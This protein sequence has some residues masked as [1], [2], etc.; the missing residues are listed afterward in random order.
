MRLG[1]CLLLAIAATCLFVNSSNAQGL[2]S[3]KQSVVAFDI[4]IAKI[5]SGSLAQKMHFDDMI[6]EAQRNQRMNEVDLTKVDRIIG[7]VSA[8]EGIAAVAGMGRGDNLPMDFFVRILFSDAAGAEKMYQEFLGKSKVVEANGRTFLRP[9][10]E[11]DPQNI[12]ICRIDPKT[13]EFGT[14]GY[15]M[16]TTRNFR[17]D[18]LTATWNAMPNSPVRVAVDLDGAQALITEAVAMAQQQLPPQAMMFVDMVT[19]MSTLSIV[20]DPDDSP[21]LLLTTTGKDAEAATA[22]E[23]TLNGVL[24]MARV[25]GQQAV[26]SMKESDP[27]LAAAG[28]SILASLQAKRNDSVVTVE[29]Q[30]PAGLEE[31]LSAAITKARGTAQR[32]KGM[33]DVKQVAL[34]IHNFE[35]SYGRLPWAPLNDQSDDLSWRARVLPFVEQARLYDQLDMTKGAADAPNSQFAD[36]M[37]IVFGADGSHS[38]IY[39]VSHDVMPSRFRDIIDGMSNTIMLIQTDGD[40]PWL[41][42]GDLT[43]DE[44]V[45]VITSLPPGQSVNVGFYDGSVRAMDSSASADNLRAMMTY[46]GKEV[47]EF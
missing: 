24:G 36:Q 38:G 32:M 18:K 15:V 41:K 34:A 47:I 44:A 42:K 17:T 1:I 23:A 33:N 31:A 12:S 7:S 21:M 25:G 40:V 11:N 9:K 27:E 35:A 39:T 16:Q 37:P 29:I 5:R 13:I 19:K 14:D 22:I 26:D 3:A 10:T 45:T 43:I 2:D 6:A 30:R 4:Q 46:N 20:A 28:A 8:P